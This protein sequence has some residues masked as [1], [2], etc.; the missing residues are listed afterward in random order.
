M[1]MEDVIL[2][3]RNIVKF[4]SEP[5]SEELVLSWL[6]TASYAPNHRRN[7]PWRMLWIGPETRAKLN[8][9]TNFAAAPIVLAF[10][11]EAGKTPLER[12]ENL[13]AVSC[14]MQNFCLLAHAAGAGTRWVS[15]GASDTSREILGVPE[16]DVVVSILAVGYPEELPEAR[17][18]EPISEKLTMMP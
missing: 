5:L 8:H 10:L 13:T 6:T 12:D 11:S 18:R 14:M 4:T 1:K 2:G 3:R 17:P 9:K 7:Q 15:H 16:G